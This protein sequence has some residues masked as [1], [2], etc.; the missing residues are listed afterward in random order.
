MQTSGRGNDGFLLLVPIGVSVVLAVIMLGG[1]ANAMEFV[2]AVLR[3]VS[4]GLITT[5]SAWF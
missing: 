4:S 1:P 3:D 5:V 2:D